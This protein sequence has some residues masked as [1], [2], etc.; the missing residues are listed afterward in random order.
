MAVGW[1]QRGTQH[2]GFVGF[3]VAAPNLHNLHNLGLIKS[4]FL[5]ANAAMKGR[6]VIMIAITINI[7]IPINKISRQFLRS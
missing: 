2:P 5:T 4:S 6:I 7:G 1:V 3:R